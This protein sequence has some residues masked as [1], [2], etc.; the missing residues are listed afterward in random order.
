MRNP[1]IWEWEIGKSGNLG[2]GNREIRKCGLQ[3]SRN[4]EMWA[5][6]IKKSGNVVLAGALLGQI[7]PNRPQSGAL[8]GLSCPRA[9]QDRPGP[10]GQPR[11][12]PKT[13]NMPSPWGG[14]Y[15]R[16]GGSFWACNIWG[17]I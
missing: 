11:E 4:P 3:K 13:S 1:E 2:V 12:A 5:P 17:N 15:I 6:G 8:F 9:G 7:W 16:I 10:R 14:V